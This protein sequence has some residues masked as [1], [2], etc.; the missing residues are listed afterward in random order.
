MAVLSLTFLTNVLVSLMVLMMS[1]FCMFTHGAL[2]H[3]Y[4]TS[5]S[6]NSSV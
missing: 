1:L 3:I 4:R 6:Q 2:P 5:S